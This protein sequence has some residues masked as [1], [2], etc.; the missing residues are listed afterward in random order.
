MSPDVNFLLL[1]WNSAH[2]ELDYRRWAADQS[3]NGCGL[4]MNVG[5]TAFKSESIGDT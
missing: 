1:K 4:V 3:G 2:Q 5:G